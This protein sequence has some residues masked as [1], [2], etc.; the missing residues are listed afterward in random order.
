MRKPFVVPFIVGFLFFLSGN[1]VFA[2][3]ITIQEAKISVKGVLQEI[4]RQSGTNF[5]YNP[6]AINTDQ[7]ISF[8]VKNA[9]LK[10]T[11]D[12]LSRQAPIDWVL[13]ENQIVLT[14]SERQPDPE[15]FT[16]SGFLTDHTSGE[17][18]PG[19]SVFV[20]ALSRGTST[21]AFGFYSLL[22]PKG[23]HFVEY[24]Y[25]GF[26]SKKL[27]MDLEKDQKQNMSLDQISLALPDVLVKT[28]TSDLLN[29]KQ[30]GAM[31]I[32]P[33]ELRNMPE[34]AGESGLIKS[35]ESLP[36]LKLHS[37]GSAF[38]FARGGEKD[39]N[40]I[41][42]DDAPIYNPAHLFGFYSIV[43]PEFTKS[44]QVYKNDMPVSLGDRLSS[45]IDIRTKDGNLN[46]FEYGGSFNPLLF[47]LS[48]EGPIE[49]EKS[50]FFVSLRQSNFRWLYGTAFPNAD[51]YFNDF[52]VKWNYLFSDK[53][54]L[55]FTLFRA[56]DVLA[57]NASNAGINWGNLALTLRWNYLF[58]P[59][60]FSNT[61]LSSS[62]YLYE[63]KGGGNKWSS[64]IAN[65]TLKTN[66]TYYISDRWT[67]H[68]GAELH[69]YYFNPGQ[70]STSLPS[71]LIP[72]AAATL[73]RKSVLYGNA[74]YRLPGKWQLNAGLRL[75]VWDNL[76]PATYFTFDEN[77]Q[78]QDTVVIDSGL[79]QQYVNLDPRL[80]LS[81][82]P[83]STSSFKLS[84][85]QY[86]QYMQLISNSESPFTSLEVWLPSSP[87][88]QP[89][90]A[91]QWSLGYL[92]YFPEAKVDFR[93]ELY[94]KKMDH[95]I[96]Y[97][98]HAN[99]LVNPL[100][101]GELRFGQTRSYGL[102]LFVKKDFGKW[103]G[104]ASYTYSRTLRQ[105][106][107]V[108]GGREYP[109]FHDRP[110][111]VSVLLNYEPH[112]R[113]TLSAFWTAYTGSAFSSPTGFY[114]FNG[115]QIP[116]YGEKNNDR[117]PNYNRLDLSLRYALNKNPDNKYKHNLTFSIYNAL[118]HE[119]V[120]AVNFN[121]I[122]DDN[123]QPVVQA[124]FIGTQNLV[125]TQIDLIRFFPSLTYRFE[126]N[127]KKEKS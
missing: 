84:Y 112:P 75:P 1:G 52:S 127:A 122:L 19:A 4:S 5:S 40:L 18:L 7:R 62:S 30:L 72:S 55:F 126:W 76:A 14:Y 57:D 48:L 123:A 41:I 23:R 74:H 106:P 67:S 49:K 61:I 22:L 69:G 43:I 11:L 81:Y 77:Y 17:S 120:V 2:Q 68:F 38:F 111:D 121:K 114:T 113:W 78:L 92:K 45:V 117:L 71:T 100:L 119:N 6:E 93:A 12:A 109:A 99:T 125:T 87:T 46:H 56:T 89:Q 50:S 95:Q 105:T 70:V 103:Y 27:S 26:D 36:G 24:S 10:E 33:G 110:H 80:S 97:E 8:Y 65:I 37:D 53:S 79:Y 98:A 31:H 59:K 28:P 54:R 9:S 47:R 39:Q 21:N 29:K 16:I 42:I 32:N 94:Y 58:N 13:V 115:Q 91:Q 104:W 90:R 25:I 102:E 107:D 35:L 88:I 66:F 60:L 85:G 51:L 82:Q 63:L 108:N 44:I 118:A 15:F 101:E 96:D 124:N 20:R 34:F 3:N 83:D 73:S 86:H 116:L 64:G